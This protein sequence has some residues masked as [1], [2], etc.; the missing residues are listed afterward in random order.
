VTRRLPRILVAVAAAAVVAAMAAPASGSV[1][2]RGKPTALSIFAKSTGASHAAALAEDEG[3][4]DHGVDADEAESVKLRGEFEQSIVAAPAV[5]APAAGL[6]AAQQAASALPVAGGSWDEVTDKP[7]LNDPVDRGANFGVGW[8]DV[9]GRMTA[10]T[11]SGST[12]YAAAASGGVWR[13]TDNGTTWTETNAGLPRISVGAL[14]TNPADGSVWVGTGEA[15]NA[16]ENQYGVGVFRLAKGSTTWQKVG[17][18]ELFGAGSFRI[19]W[20]NGYVYVATSHGLYRRAA[21]AAMSSPWKLVLA[22]AGVKDYPPSSSVTDVLA[23][24]GSNG[25]QVLAVVGWAGYSVP[26]A[27]FFNGFYVGSGAPGSFSKITPTGDINPKEIGRTTFSVSNGWLYAVVQDTANDDLRGEGVFVS[28]SGN[29]AG[30]WKLIADTDKLAA[31]ESALGDST[32]SYYPGIQSDYN[33]NIVADPNDRKHVYLQLEEMFE[34]TDGGTTW[35]AVGPYWNYDIPCDPNDDD[36]Y[37]CPGTTHPD[38]HAGMI[39]N[40]AFW[41]G[42]DGGVW[43][44]PLTWHQRGHWTNLNATLHTTQNYSIAVGK[45]GKHNLAYWGGLQDNGESYTTTKLPQVEQAFTGDGGDTI[46]DP[47][48]GNKAVEEYVYLDTF[49]TTDGAVADLREIS[50]SCLSATDPP[51]VCDPNPRFIAP[52]EMDVKNSNHW[53]AG[54][55]YVWDDKKAWN[56]VCSGAAGKCDWKVV[57]DTGDG[58]QVTA[59][60]DN[61]KVTYAGWCG[62]CNPPTF[63]RGMATN[64]GG[65]WHE[66]ALAGV[67][68]RYIT[69]IAVDPK[70][71]AHV[72]ISIG[73][74][75][76]R[77]I[78]DAGYGHVFESWNGGATFSDVTGNLP[79]APV[80]KVVMVGD[81]LVAGTEVGAFVAE[82]NHGSPMSWFQLGT[83]LPN[84]TVWD[85]TVGPD[86][87]VVAGTHGRGDWEIK[88]D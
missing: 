78:P 45:V 61:G 19:V 52:V 38:Q 25:A 77:W 49:V 62:G 47:K 64:Y 4:G 26:P 9:T 30:P 41:T 70:N 50:P 54:G 42:N 73:S 51:A 83:G 68:N 10:L 65:T 55:Q 60:A 82:Q 88:L 48:D 6:V 39:Y 56:T 58:H 35:L 40:G 7:F 59:L 17:G 69:S 66:L 81:K 5:A 57:Y 46:V 36:P 8:G 72:F 29:P 22:P 63:A 14:G 27:T 23:V 15:N 33:Q 16:S 84:V 12:V 67:P 79:D 87:L 24:P 44:R 37:N 43:R 74:Y 3:D 85:I 75:S 80:F 18:S 20:I 34:S 13:S 53:V 86:D 2:A 28:K 11:H 76:R 32:S 21:G 1:A 31:S 71:A